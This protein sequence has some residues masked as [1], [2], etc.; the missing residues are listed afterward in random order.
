M[1]QLTH[2]D[3]QAAKSRLANW[4]D[5]RQNR[6]DLCGAVID[7]PTRP[8][9]SIT[10]LKYLYATDA[11]DDWSY[12]QN[13]KLRCVENRTSPDHSMGT[14]LNSLESDCAGHRFHGMR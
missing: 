4:K 10:P 3:R 13:V 8:R 9:L 2:R 11:R 1:R 12:S 5:E 14:L 6:P 7:A